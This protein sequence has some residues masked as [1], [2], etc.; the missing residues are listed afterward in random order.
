MEAVD[1]L[2]EIETHAGLGLARACIMIS[3]FH[4]S[5]CAAK[6]SMKRILDVHG[7]VFEASQINS[8]PF[9]APDRLLSEH[10]GIPT[11]ALEALLGSEVDPE[12]VLS[13]QKF[14][15]TTNVSECL[16]TLVS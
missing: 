9:D 2:G 11:T 8:K 4:G 3:A 13:L 10:F 16:G 1:V 7:D 14:V 15:T 12:T 6:R 5:L